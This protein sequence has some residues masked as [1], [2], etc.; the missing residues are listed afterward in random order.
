MLKKMLILFFAIVYLN[1]CGDGPTETIEEDK[2]GRR[3]YV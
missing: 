2:P 1:T 3:D